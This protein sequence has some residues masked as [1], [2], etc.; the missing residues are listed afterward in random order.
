MTI[1]VTLVYNDDLDSS[2]HAVFQM[3]LPSSWASK[4]CSKL[5]AQFASAYAAKY[6]ACTLEASTLELV[7]LD[8]GVLLNT[9]SMIG[10]EVKDGAELAVYRAAPIVLV[11]GEVET[12]VGLA[13]D[14]APRAKCP[15]YVKEVF[16]KSVFESVTAAGGSAIERLCKDPRLSK[17]R[18]PIGSWS[19]RYE[20]RSFGKHEAR[21]SHKG[22]ADVEIIVRH[23]LMEAGLEMHDRH[24]IIAVPSRATAAFRK[25]LMAML[26]L[27]HG[28]ASACVV[29]LSACALASCG[30]AT[31][32]VIDCGHDSSC[33][34]AYVD[35]AY[36]R[37][38]WTLRGGSA[39]SRLFGSL[40]GIPHDPNNHALHLAKKRLCRLDDCAAPGRVSLGS[41]EYV[42]SSQDASLSGEILFAKP[43][44]CPFADLAD[45]TPLDDVVV[46]T[47]LACDPQHFA[48]LCGGI[49]V[50]GSDDAVLPGLELR[51][52][53]RLVRSINYRAYVVSNRAYLHHRPQPHLCSDGP[54]LAQYPC[55]CRHPLRS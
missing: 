32:C 23:V 20:K 1:R 54:R 30:Q 5:K 38:R 47:I 7:R 21:I 55:L 2:R 27:Q 25:E 12:S 9:T 14:A 48:A 33:A 36:Q 15:S 35:G 19:L 4:P 31:A 41:T 46:Q 43:Q 53:T 11:L 6:A 3:Q 13:S 37:L 17:P 8:D 39:V 16:P 49:I 24:A 40:V 42:V 18:Y 34:I 51:L 44:E 26:L 50:T 10:E 52:A 28:A 22:W 29:P 45:A